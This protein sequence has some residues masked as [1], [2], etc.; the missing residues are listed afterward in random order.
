MRYREYTVKLP[1]D[2]SCDE[3]GKDL[4]FEM[5]HDEDGQYPHLQDEK[6]PECGRSTDHAYGMGSVTSYREDFGL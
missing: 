4:S 2:P 5:K 1:I 3:C 6:C